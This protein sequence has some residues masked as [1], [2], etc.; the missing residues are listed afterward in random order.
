[1]EASMKVI[2]YGSLEESTFFQ[3]ETEDKTSGRKTAIRFNEDPQFAGDSI[4]YI[5]ETENGI[6]DGLNTTRYN[7]NPTFEVYVAGYVY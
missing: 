2:R 3:V 4:T 5:Y 6:K 1:M 7:S